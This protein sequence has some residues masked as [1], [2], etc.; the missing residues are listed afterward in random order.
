MSTRTWAGKFPWGAPLNERAHSEDLEGL[1]S[2]MRRWWY[3]GVSAMKLRK[4]N[5]TLLW[6]ASAPLAFEQYRQVCV[7]CVRDLSKNWKPVRGYEYSSWSEVAK[8][9]YLFFSWYRPVQ[10]FD[11]RWD[12]TSRSFDTRRPSA[13]MYVA[14][15]FTTARARLKRQQPTVI[16]QAAPPTKP[17]KATPTCWIHQ[18]KYWLEAHLVGSD[19]VSERAGSSPHCDAE[20]HALDIEENY[21][22]I[23]M[24]SVWQTG[25]METANCI[26]GWSIEFLSN[27]AE[28]RGVTKQVVTRNVKLLCPWSVLLKRKL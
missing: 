10:K 24:A 12:A 8:A 27:C 22:Q 7:F 19:T 13:N 3:P 16:T 17:K 20:Y 9:T 21:R 1:A 25:C 18:S 15:A 28:I 23:S 4:T 2:V 11:R 14:N 6:S 5:A 26:D